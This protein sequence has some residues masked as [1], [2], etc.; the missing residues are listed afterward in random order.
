MPPAGQL[1]G[2]EVAALAYSYK[3]GYRA[4]PLRA[5]TFGLGFREFLDGAA[6]EPTGRDTATTLPG[7]WDL[8]IRA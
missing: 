4:H 5:T 6:V 3:V 1:S 7:L 2:D 8:T